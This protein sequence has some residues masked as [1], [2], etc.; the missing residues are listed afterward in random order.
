MV[1]IYVGGV[2]GLYV[3]NPLTQENP[4][5]TVEIADAPEEFNM[6][7]SGEAAMFTVTNTGSE[8]IPISN[9]AIYIGPVDS[10]VEFS[11]RRIW[12]F[13]SG[14]FVYRV[15]HNGTWLARSDEEQFDPGES[16]VL[17]KIRG[18]SEEPA[19]FEIR[20][21]V[22]ERDSETELGDVVVDVE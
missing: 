12:E 22:E 18:S 6:T 1:I 3:G 14:D 21:R 5:K 4:A 10:D 9:L 19:E 7:H 15:H 8:S 11:E 16:L 20:V 13:Q 17:K 2:V